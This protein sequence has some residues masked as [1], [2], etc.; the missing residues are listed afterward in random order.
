MD[1]VHFPAWIFIDISI[2]PHKKVR[3]R[4]G[5]LKTLRENRHNSVKIHDKRNFPGPTVLCI[6]RKQ[7][8]PKMSKCFKLLVTPLT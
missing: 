8:I 4:L 6:D 2:T 3:D 1:N 5:T 7:G